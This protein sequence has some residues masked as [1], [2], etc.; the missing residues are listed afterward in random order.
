[1]ILMAI[2]LVCLIY[3]LGGPTTGS[4]RKELELIGNYLCLINI[5]YRKG[6]EEIHG[7]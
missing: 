4:Y 3:N 5:K 7:C 2:S 6:G 1:M